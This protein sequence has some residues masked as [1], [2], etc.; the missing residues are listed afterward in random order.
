MF[1]IHLQVDEKKNVHKNSSYD[2][3]LNELNLY[4]YGESYRIILCLGQSSRVVL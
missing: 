4:V 2:L 3:T 1:S